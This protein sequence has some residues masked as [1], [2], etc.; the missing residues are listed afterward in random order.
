MKN[1]IGKTSKPVSTESAI[2]PKSRNSNS[3]VQ[4]Q[5]E[6]NSQCEFVPRDTVQ[7]EFFRFGGF[8]GCC[9]FSGD[10][11]VYRHT[12]LNKLSCNN[13]WDTHPWK[14]DVKTHIPNYSKRHAFANNFERHISLNNLSRHRPFNIL[15]LNTVSLNHL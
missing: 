9:I 15:S 11:H 2:P 5:I 4:I 10:C 6:P 12:P 3:S 14:I 7:F 8:R 1:T 13:L